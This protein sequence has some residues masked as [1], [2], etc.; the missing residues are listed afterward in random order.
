MIV[1]CILLGCV[2]EQFV[3]FRRSKFGRNLAGGSM[4]ISDFGAA[5]NSW[6]PLNYTYS[7]FRMQVQ[8]GQSTITGG[9]TLSC[10]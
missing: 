10:F 1:F 9:I 5:V 2:A 6:A 4:E 8:L 7:V 3:R